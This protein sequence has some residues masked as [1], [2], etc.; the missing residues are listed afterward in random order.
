MMATTCKIAKLLKG[1]EYL[2]RVKAVNKYG[3]GE[4]LESEPIKAMD[5]FTIPSAPT[6]I[7]V[8]CVTSEAMTVCWKRPTSDG[9]SC[10]SGYMIEKREKQGLRWMRVNKKSVNDLRVKA[11]GLHEGCEYEFR[12]YA[13]NA[14]GI[15][16]PSLP[17]PLTLAEDPKFLPSPPAKPTIIDSSRS[18]ATLSWNRPMF[19]GGATI[20]G[21]KVEFKK[22]A[23]ESWVVAV[24]NTDKTGV[25]VTGLTPG[26]EY[27]FVVRSINTIGISDPSPQTDC[28]VAA[29]REEE[30]RFDI[31]TEM[32]KTLQV[33]VG[34]T[35]TFI[36]PFTGKPAPKVIWA[37]A[38]VDLRVRGMINT[39]SSVTS[40]TVEQATRDDSGKYTVKLQNVVGSASL[41]LSVR[42]L[43]SPG[44]PTHVTVKDV[45]ENSATVKWDIPDNEGG[46]AVKNYLVDCR[47]IH[48]KG[49]TRLTDRCHRLS[50]RVFDLKKG[51][52]YFFRVTGENEYGIGVPAETKEGTKMTDTSD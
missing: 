16:K 20:T 13:E 4:T 26:A 44:P 50:W 49:W 17:S 23:E 40:I 3:E 12:V 9:G 37:K 51:G 8:T 47:D 48:R 52:I 30:P 11:S 45:T 2:F 24:H 6:D 25:T 43:D 41:T 33:K 28:L 34:G 15:S 10:I 39:T 38:D 42:V 7:E 18:S 46:A 35:F 32:R 5:P 19:D 27:V 36:V 31:S 21:Y 14:A 29:E 22:S 1:N